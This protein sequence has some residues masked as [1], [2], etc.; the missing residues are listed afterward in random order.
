[1]CQFSE[2]ANKETLA[3]YFSS[4]AKDVYPVGRLYYD[5]EGLLLLTNDKAINNKLLHPRFAHKGNVGCK[6]KARLRQAQW[7]RWAKAL[8]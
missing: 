1:M 6:W 3:K 5:S 2:A 8:P 7:R 4:I